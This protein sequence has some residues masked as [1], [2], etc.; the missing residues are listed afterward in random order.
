MFC[1]LG[2]VT[3]QRAM[4]IASSGDDDPNNLQSDIQRDMN[5]SLNAVLVYDTKGLHAVTY[6]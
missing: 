5:L 4:R 1:Q 2:I 6:Y 3:V